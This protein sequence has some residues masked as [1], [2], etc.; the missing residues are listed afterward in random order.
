MVLN[1]S[2]LVVVIVSTELRHIYSNDDNDILLAMHL[3]STLLLLL[4]LIHAQTYVRALPPIQALLPS[5]KEDYIVQHFACAGQGIS[6][7]AI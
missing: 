5:V 3:P 7:G 6:C 2:Q 1:G 4:Q